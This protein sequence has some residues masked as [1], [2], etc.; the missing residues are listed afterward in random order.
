MKH[1]ALAIGCITLT[2]ALMAQPGPQGPQGL[3]G[4]HGQWWTLPQVQ[5]ALNLSQEQIDALTTLHT[6]HAEKMIDLRANLEKLRLKMDQAL[7]KDPFVESEALRLADEINR[8]RSVMESA[9]TE[10]LIKS[11]AILTLE[12]WN[13]M[14]AHRADR[15]EKRQDRREE[16]REERGNRDRDFRGDRGFRR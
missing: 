5:E 6:A 8:A 16:F 1:L 10:M 15:K 14:K 12:Q 13:Q 7:Q 4:P 3:Q 2:A 9:R 11:R